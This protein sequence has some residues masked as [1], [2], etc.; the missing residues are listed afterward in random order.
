MVPIGKTT[1]FN[2]DDKTFTVIGSERD[3]SV[4]RELE[5][6]NGQYEPHITNLLPEIINPNF[7]C[8][9]IGANIGVIIL[10]LSSLSR[11]GHVYSIEASRYNYHF[12]A[13]N[14]K[15]NDAKNV[16]CMNLA[17]YDTN[18][19]LD[20]SY[21][22]EFAGGSFATTTEFVH[23]T[24]IHETV[25]CVKLD[26][27]VKSNFLARLDF[28][29]LD[30]EGAEIKV[31][32]GGKDA[33]MEFKP[34]LIVEFNPHTLITFFKQRAEALFELLCSLFPN[35]YLISREDGALKKIGSFN[36]LQAFFPT[37]LHVQDLYC[38]F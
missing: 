35:V 30:V 17:I 2:F 32:E 29:K 37:E 23:P 28:V 38:T 27:W 26:D 36:E 13:K 11:D 7:V 12:L 6:H 9:D 10:A 34:R 4:V 16:T 22:D 19:T 24:A 8:L 33:L 31:L 25:R 20:I 15:L 21:V 5:V 1:F 18:G 3:E 14:I